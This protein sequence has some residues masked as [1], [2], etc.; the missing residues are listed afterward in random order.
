MFHFVSTWQLP[1]TGEHIWQVLSDFER[2]PAW[3]PGISG[4]TVLHP[5]GTDGLG[6]RGRLEV[7]SPLGYSMRF[8]IE[9]V[10]VRRPHES[11][12]R[13]T[14]DLQGTGSWEV[15]PTDT[16]SRAR[17]GWDVGLTRR[18]MQLIAARIPGPVVWAHDWVM[19]AGERGLA[20][21]LLS[22]PP[23]DPAG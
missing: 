2:W 22:H 11:G 12:M 10:E 19:A 21:H 8:D 9:I 4:A 20:R 14:G 13:V 15:T 3:W 6:T 5:G 7:R 1:A 23:V 16:G 17:I 18:G